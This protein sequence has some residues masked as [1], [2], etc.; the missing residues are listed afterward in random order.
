MKDIVYHV[1]KESSFTRET[2]DGKYHAEAADGFVHMSTSEEL[3]ETLRIWLSKVP[4]LVLLECDAS[5]LPN[6]KWDFVESRNAHFPHVYSECIPL[7]AVLRV[8]PLALNSDG[9][10][11]LPCDLK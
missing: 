11:T 1:C 3:A 6:L 9:V 4:G 7:D 8:M 5:K 2:S 10:H